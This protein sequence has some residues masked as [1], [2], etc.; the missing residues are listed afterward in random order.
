ML[1]IYETLHAQADGFLFVCNVPG[2][3]WYGCSVQNLWDFV[4]GVPD[5]MESVVKVISTWR[6]GSTFLHQ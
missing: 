6:F 1:E 5:C 3:H 4:N 2:I